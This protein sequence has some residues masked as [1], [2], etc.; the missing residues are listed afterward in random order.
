MLKSLTARRTILLKGK[1]HLSKLVDKASRLLSR[2]FDG[3]G[4]TVRTGLPRCRLRLSS[5]S[6][7]AFEETA[8]LSYASR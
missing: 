4:A 3:H 7:E 1:L 2:E 6:S 5:H 8:D